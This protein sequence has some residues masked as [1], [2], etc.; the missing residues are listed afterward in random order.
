MFFISC[1][2]NNNVYNYNND[3]NQNN[4]NDNYNNNKV[5]TVAL[6]LGVINSTALEA[7]QTSFDANGAVVNGYV[8]TH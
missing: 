2:I 7:T 1:I 8:G 3:N 5:T 6:N 4:N